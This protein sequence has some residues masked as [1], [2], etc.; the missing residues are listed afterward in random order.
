MGLSVNNA[1]ACDVCGCSVGGSYFG[2]LPQF[3]RNFIGWRYQQRSFISEHLTLFPNEVPIKSQESFYTTEAWGRYV[4]HPKVHVFAFVPFNY[5][6]KREDSMFTKVAGIGDVSLL[7]H[8]IVFNT[9]DSTALKWKQ[10]LQLGA[11][12]KLPTGKSNFI[13]EHTGLLVPSLQPGTGSLDIPLSVIYTVRKGKWGINAEINYRVN[14]PNIRHYKFGDRTTTYVRTF[15]WYGK[16]NV[17]ILPHMGFTYERG[18]MDKKDGTIVDY[19]G[20]ESVLAS[21]GFDFY[22]KKLILNGNAQLP[23]YQHIAQGQVTSKP[24]FNVGLAFQL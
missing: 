14:T 13:Q 21:A 24:R 18:M 1:T 6:T 4:P 17:T 12:I 11:G 3:Q 19:T 20:S 23:M 5:F 22:Y 15:Y 16:R 8:F 7:A 2:I 9:G 10:A